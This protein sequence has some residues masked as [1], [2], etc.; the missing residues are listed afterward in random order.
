MMG[1]RGG[2]VGEGGDIAT[3]CIQERREDWRHRL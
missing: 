1:E 2:R 3:V